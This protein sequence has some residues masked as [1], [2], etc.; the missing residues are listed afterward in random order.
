MRLFV[1]CSWL[2][3]LLGLWLGECVCADGGGCY[4]AWCTVGID[5]DGI[6]DLLNDC[7]AGWWLDG[8]AG[9]A[10]GQGCGNVFGVDG[11]VGEDPHGVLGVGLVGGLV[12][13]DPVDGCE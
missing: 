5:E 7:A 6:G 9:D 2:C 8:P 3:L 1:L 12:V 11:M 4:L 10:V 13:L